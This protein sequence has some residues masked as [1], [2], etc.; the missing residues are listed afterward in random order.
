MSLVLK[1]KV[2][3]ITGAGRGIGKAFALRFAEEGAKIFIPDISLERAEDTVKE[4]KAKG[5]EAA[6]IMTDISDEKA[7]QKM[8]DEVMKQFGRVDILVNNAAIW[9]GINAKPWD[10]W[11]VEEWDKIFDVNVRGTWLCCKA[12]APLM[13]KQSRGKIINIVSDVIKSPDAQ[14][15][16]AYAL[17]K[18]SVYLMSQCLANALGPSGI[19]VNA[20]GPGFTASEA[21]IAQEGSAALFENVVAAQPIKRRE[22]PEDILGTAVFLASQESDFIT[23]QLIL[24]NGGHIM[25]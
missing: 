17:S 2:A 4:I 6:A 23:G 14:F 16:L 25:V 15:F 1:D 10:M 8:A 13:V 24:V 9:Y 7:T 19:N 21:S 12:I 22:E 20:I 3:V 11:T 5:G 18:S